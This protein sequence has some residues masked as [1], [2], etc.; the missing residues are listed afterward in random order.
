MAQI[1][2]KRMQVNVKKNRPGLALGYFLIV[3]LFFIAVFMHQV[4]SATVVLSY[5]ALFVVFGLV[6]IVAAIKN[7]RSF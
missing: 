2:I 1:S 3:S 4:I 5:T 7:S 6:C